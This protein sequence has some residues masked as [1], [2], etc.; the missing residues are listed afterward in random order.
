MGNK[1]MKENVMIGIMIQSNRKKRGFIRI[2]NTNIITIRL[3]RLPENAGIKW[4]YITFT[5][6]CHTTYWQ[7]LIFLKEET[8]EKHMNLQDS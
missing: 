1:G 8:H 6:C 2:M 3:H 5:I 4:L 7:E